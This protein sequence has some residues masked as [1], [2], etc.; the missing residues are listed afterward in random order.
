MVTPDCGDSLGIGL[1]LLKPGKSQVKEEELIMLNA[2]QR[3][4]LLLC[5]QAKINNFFV[6][7]SNKIDLRPIDSY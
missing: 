1:S 7:I 4:F 3:F 6:I 2:C 5:T